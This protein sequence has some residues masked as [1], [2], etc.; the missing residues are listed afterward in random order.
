VPVRPPLSGHFGQ[1][2]VQR[3]LGPA[4]VSAVKLSSDPVK[5]RIAAVLAVVVIVLSVG[6]SVVFAI[7][8]VAESDNARL[9]LN[10]LGSLVLAAGSGWLLLSVR[11][12][13]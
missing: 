1:G 4:K 7:A 2:I 6:L 3:L 13:N 9:W 11:R 8:L 5:R 12:T 10:L